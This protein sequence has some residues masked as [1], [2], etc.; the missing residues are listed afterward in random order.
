MRDTS[1]RLDVEEEKEMRKRYLKRGLPRSEGRDE[2]PRHSKR[3]MSSNIGLPGNTITWPYEGEESSLNFWLTK[4]NIVEKSDQVR[5][6][7]PYTHDLQFMTDNEEGLRWRLQNAL[8]KFDESIGTGVLMQLVFKDKNKIDKLAY[9][10]RPAGRKFVFWPRGAERLIEKPTEL[11]DTM[12]RQ[13]SLFGEDNPI[14]ATQTRVVL[15]TDKLLDLK[16]KQQSRYA[17]Q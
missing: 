3:L 1:K 13:P 7:N 2:Q 4:S 11:I 5:L 15:T 16:K 14:D 10:A 6:E 8:Y 9:S 12:A 17:Y